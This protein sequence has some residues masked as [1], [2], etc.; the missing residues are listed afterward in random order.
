VGPRPIEKAG[1]FH[2]W[3]TE[4]RRYKV[5]SGVGG[6]VRKKSGVLLPVALD[7]FF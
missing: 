1:E 6:V 2:R 4:V 7:E 3:R 5:K